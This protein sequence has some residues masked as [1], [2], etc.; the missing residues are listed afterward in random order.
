ME[1]AVKVDDVGQL[2]HEAGKRGVGGTEWSLGFRH[3]DVLAPGLGT[4]GI[5]IH[6]PNN[7]S[8]HPECQRSS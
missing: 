5:S 8:K 2:C 7:L 1:F 6:T 3:M 4:K